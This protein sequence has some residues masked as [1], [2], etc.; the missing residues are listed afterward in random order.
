M[1]TTLATLLASLII[2]TQLAAQQPPPTAPPAPAAQTPQPAPPA[3]TQNR[4]PAPST[5]TNVRLDLT[6]TDTYG[7][8]PS[9]KTVSMIVVDR[10]RSSIRTSNRLPGGQS[11]QLNVDAYASLLADRA[12]RIL[13]RLTFEYTP[14]Q[15]AAGTEG[16]GPAPAELTESL[17]VVLDNAQKLVVSQSADPATDRK[18]TVE[19]TA[20]VLK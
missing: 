17:S 16:R 10:E 11:V 5:F 18:V 8:K 19:V 13:L 7:D 15:T 12:N 4:P 14:A 9:S 20:T 1:R 3:P 2:T 6:I